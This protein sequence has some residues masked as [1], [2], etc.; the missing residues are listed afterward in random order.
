MF[1][2]VAP[3]WK[4]LTVNDYVKVNELDVLVSI[5]I[6]IESIYGMEKS[7]SRRIYMM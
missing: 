4:C 3:N 5:C 6:N 1:S 7:S 2:V